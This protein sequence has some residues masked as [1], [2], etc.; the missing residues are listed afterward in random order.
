MDQSAGCPA[1]VFQ[2]PAPWLDSLEI[3]ATWSVVET[4]FGWLGVLTGATG[5]FRVFIGFDTRQSLLAALTP[6][7]SLAPAPHPVA[8]RL[9]NYLQ[10]ERD[11]LCDIPLAKV[12][13]TPFQQQ[14]VQALRQVPYGHTTT[15]GELA[16]RVG[17]PRAARA[18]GQVMA[19]NPVPLIVPCHR[20]LGA[21]GSL[22][23]FSAPNGL[24]LKQ[25]L[26]T[27][28]ATN[29][30]QLHKLPARAESLSR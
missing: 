18:V 27:L 30:G 19:T 8:R 22:G 24:L 15:Y 7:L 10:G 20:V 12:W 26:L 1:P 11:E 29:A 28:E 13:R 17:R 9:Q 23:G 14:V 16:R 4:P 3:S 25:R 2:N 21:G 5:V 6:P